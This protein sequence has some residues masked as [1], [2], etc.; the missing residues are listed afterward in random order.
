MWAVSSSWDQI[1]PDNGRLIT[2]YSTYNWIA[3]VSCVPFA[4]PYRQ[5]LQ[6]R[7]FSSVPLRVG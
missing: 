4:V 6:S 5:V 1:R 7:K 3:G 2:D